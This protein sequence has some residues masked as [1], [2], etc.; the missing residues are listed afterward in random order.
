[1]LE[2]AA[3]GLISRKIKVGESE[4]KFIIRF[5]EGK[6]R[7]GLAEKTVL[8][9]LADAMVIHG[10]REKWDTSYQAVKSWQKEKRFSR[11]S[12][13]KNFNRTLYSLA[14]RR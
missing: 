11:P 3:K 12:T 6:L 14:D 13:G 1:M 7:L 4:A 8:V 2:R 5:L 9:A 10:D